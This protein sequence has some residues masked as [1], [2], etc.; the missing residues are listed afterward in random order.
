MKNLQI[1][2]S[3]TLERIT[4]KRTGEKKLHEVVQYL[5]SSNNLLERITDPQ[6]EFVLFG[7]KDAIPNN[8]SLQKVSQL[9]SSD[10]SRI[11]EIIED[12][13]INKLQ[14]L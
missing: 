2:N 9:K 5:T 4:Q 11:F 10:N 12:K 8:L 1:I 14:H 6:I 3:E 7:I 13:K